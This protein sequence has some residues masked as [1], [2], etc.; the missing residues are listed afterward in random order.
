MQGAGEI[1]MT[2]EEH[3]S[4]SS[5]SLENLEGLTEKVSTLGLQS[6]KESLWHCQEASKGGQASEAPTGDSGSGQLLPSQG[7]QQNL[8]KPG[9]SGAQRKTKER[10]KYESSSTVPESSESKGHLK[11]P[12]QMTKA[13]WGHN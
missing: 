9:T 10:T 5:L 3:L 6:S 2:W 7:S 12:R 1:P 4:P 8:Q 11:G 13:V